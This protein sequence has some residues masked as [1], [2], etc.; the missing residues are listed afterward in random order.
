MPRR[1]CRF[2]PVS[3]SFEKEVLEALEK[4]CEEEKM[5]KSKFV[6]DIIRTFVINEY[7]FYKKRAKHHSQE[8][9]RYRVLMESAPDAPK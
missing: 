5:K 6:N 3:I 8:M 2:E 7:V 9:E 1:N 4:R